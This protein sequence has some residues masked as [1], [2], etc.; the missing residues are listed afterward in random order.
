MDAWAGLADGSITRTLRTWAKPQAKVGSV[1]RV[2]D[3]LR[4]EVDAVTR[5]PVAD[6]TDADAV[7]AGEPDLAALRKRLGPKVGDGDEVWRVDFHLAAGPDPRA[8]LA[9]TDELDADAVAEIDRRL[10]RLDAASP[11]GPWTRATLDVIAA[12][13]AV[14]SSVLAELLGRDR[15]AL[16]LDVRKLK[17]LGLTESLGTGYRV[18]RRGEAYRQARAGGA[19]D[20]RRGRPSPSAG[21]PS[22]RGG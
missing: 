8:E 6:L 11:V 20:G 5:V 2:G 13:P 15:P 12:H 22:R 1:H 18:S 16:K 21:R 3:G 10:D 7:A 19:A 9:A 4:I 14:V 17:N